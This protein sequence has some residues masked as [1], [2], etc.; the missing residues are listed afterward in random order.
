MRN[1]GCRRRVEEL[2]MSEEGWGIGA[3]GGGLRNWGCRRRV[4][5]LGLSEEG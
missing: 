1:W 5:E 3:V 2:G 4:G